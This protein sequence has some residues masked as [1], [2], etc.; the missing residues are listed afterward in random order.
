MNRLVVALC[1]IIII[2]D[3]CY[4][5]AA[6]ETVLKD[7]SAVILNATSLV[8]N[9]LKA[10]GI[11]SD[12]KATSKQKAD[13]LSDIVRDV[14]V[15]AVLMTRSIKVQREF[16]NE[17]KG[18]FATDEGQEYLQQLKLQIAFLEQKF[19]LKDL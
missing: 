12:E 1:V 13:I 19:I 18:F 5:I 16:L 10:A 6:E 3:S 11:K 17:L 7:N 2:K 8:A 14:G 4:I 9:I 15:L